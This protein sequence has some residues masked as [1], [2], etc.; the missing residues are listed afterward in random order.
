VITISGHLGKLLGSIVTWPPC[1][2][3]WW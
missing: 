1:W 2:N 3:D